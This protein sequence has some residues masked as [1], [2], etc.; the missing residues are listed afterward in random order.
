MNRELRAN[1]IFHI[2]VDAGE[3]VNGFSYI[4][5]GLGRGY[6]FVS[7]TFNTPITVHDCFYTRF[8]PI[9]LI[10]GTEIPAW[11]TI[12]V[13]T[14]RIIAVH[15]PALYNRMFSS[16]MKMMLIGV[17][18]SCIM[19]SL[20]WAAL[21]ALTPA[22]FHDSTSTQHCAII[23]STSKAFSTF[24]FVF[25]P[26]AYFASF[27]SLCTIA[28]F[29]RKTS[30]N[31]TKS[32]KKGPMLSIFIATTAFDV[33]LC[34]APSIVMISASWQLFKPNDIIVSITYATTGFVS[35]F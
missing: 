4:L 3:I 5:T 31:V 8:W 16:N 13:S 19:A 18:G 20:T 22:A 34:S 14:E 27:V 24:H 17:A 7:G 9:S 1:Y 6:H 2:I 21:S 28:Y 32:G 23:S 15:K 10:L 35:G 11:M 29:H 30:R 26:F 12:L 25:V 33:I